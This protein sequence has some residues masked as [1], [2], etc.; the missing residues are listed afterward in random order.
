MAK[1]F[2]AGGE[3][4]INLTVGSGITSGTPIAVGQLKGTVETDADSD[5]KAVVNVHP[6]A[7][8]EHSVRNV[9]TYAA[10]AE[11]T[12]GAIA[13]GD[14]IYL[15]GS[16]TMPSGVYL[17]TSPLDDAGSANKL[18]GKAT[19]ADSTATANTATIEVIQDAVKL[20]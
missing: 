15:D 18:F 6:T 8:Y 17:S 16:A 19:T 9:L 7:T 13:E 10:S 1:K 3:R 14:L 2:I 12:W 20:T 4:N 5:N 11:A